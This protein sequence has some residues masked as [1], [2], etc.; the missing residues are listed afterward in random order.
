MKRNQNR[1]PERQ[2]AAQSALMELYR[3]HGVPLTTALISSA[4]GCNFE[5]DIQPAPIVELIGQLL[6]ITASQGESLKTVALAD[7]MVW[8]TPTPVRAC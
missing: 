1:T 6:D 8:A 3:R 7:T 4:F 5:N 2:L